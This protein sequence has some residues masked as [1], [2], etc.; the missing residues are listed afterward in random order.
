MNIIVK[1][2][3]DHCLLVSLFEG[4][5]SVF[6]CDKLRSLVSRIVLHLNTRS[7]VTFPL[8]HRVCFIPVADDKARVVL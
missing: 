3:V 6:L 4:E 2:Q 7:S 1:L 5:K 8:I